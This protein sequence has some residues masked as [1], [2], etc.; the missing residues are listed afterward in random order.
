MHGVGGNDLQGVPGG[1]SDTEVDDLYGWHDPCRRL[2]HLCDGDPWAFEL[3]ADDEAYF[4]LGPYGRKAGNGHSVA[5]GEDPAAENAPERRLG[6]TELGHRAAARECHLAADDPLS[7]RAALVYQGKLDAVGVFAPELGQ[8]RGHRV[9]SLNR[10]ESG[11]YLRR[12]L[13]NPSCCHHAVLLT[14]KASCL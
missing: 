9:N 3:V 4:G 5:V 1:V 8:V 6:D 12:Q 11:Q 13:F 10:V 7:T 14:K 2:E